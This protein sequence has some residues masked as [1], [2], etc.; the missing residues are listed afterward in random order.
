MEQRSLSRNISVTD[1]KYPISEGVVELGRAGAS[2]TA[3][4]HCARKGVFEH[5]FSRLHPSCLFSFSLTLRRL[6]IERNTVSMG[7]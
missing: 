6:D 5:F 2:N 7:R 4:N 3:R 1:K